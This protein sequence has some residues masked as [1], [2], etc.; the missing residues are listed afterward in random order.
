M[1]VPDLAGTGGDGI[2]VYR[3]EDAYVLRLFVQ[4]KTVAIKL[5]GLMGLLRL[6][7]VKI[8]ILI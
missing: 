3:S 1:N 6:A 8:M 4:T 7:V 5:F 2:D